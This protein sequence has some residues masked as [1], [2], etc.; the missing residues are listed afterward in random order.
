MYSLRIIAAII[1]LVVILTCLTLISFATDTSAMAKASYLPDELMKLPPQVKLTDDLSGYWAGKDAPLIRCIMLERLWE[2]LD[3]LNNGPISLEIA[4]GLTIDYGYS[5]DLLAFYYLDDS[6][7][8]KRI[9]SFGYYWISDIEP[10]E[11]PYDEAERS[12][13]RASIGN[14]GNA[15]S[16]K[17]V[18]CFVFHQLPDG[19]ITFHD[20]APSLEGM[21]PIEIYGYWVN[22]SLVFAVYPTMDTDWEV[23]FEGFAHAGSPD[24]YILLSVE[25]EGTIT[26]VSKENQNFYLEHLGSS[27]FAELLESASL[28]RPAKEPAKDDYYLSAIIQILIDYHDM[29]YSDEGSRLA[30]KLVKAYGYKYYFGGETANQLIDDTIAKLNAQDKLIQDEIDKYNAEISAASW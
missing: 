27:N 28:G 26:N 13:L 6:G 24:R 16:Q 17:G 23:G 3:E 4:E 20:M 12:I 2:S 5:K 19:S 1:A 15:R 29:G 22:D 10:V 18:C 25:M 14:S 9:G 7:S 8:W 30:R 11:N 21:N